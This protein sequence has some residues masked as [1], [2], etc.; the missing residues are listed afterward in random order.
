MSPTASGNLSRFFRFG[1]SI[2]TA[3]R[4]QSFSYEE[5]RFQ[6]DEYEEIVCCL[7]KMDSV[8]KKDFFVAFD[9]FQIDKVDLILFYFYLQLIL[10]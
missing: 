2:G 8:E 6:G 10:F 3:P 9:I 1:S 7:T 5:K 4:K